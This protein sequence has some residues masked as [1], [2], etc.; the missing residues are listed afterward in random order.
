MLTGFMNHITKGK[1]IQHIKKRQNY[2]SGRDA[3]TMSPLKMAEVCHTEI[4]IH[5]DLETYGLS[6]PKPATKY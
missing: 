1:T 3:V 6:L 4:L 5:S 2:M